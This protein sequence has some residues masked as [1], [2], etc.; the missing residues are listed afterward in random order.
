MT[1]PDVMRHQWNEDGE[2][3]LKCGAK[4]WMG[5]PCI[6]PYANPPQSYPGAG[7]FPWGYSVPEPQSQSD[8][9]EM[10]R[11]ATEFQADDSRPKTG[12]KNSY[13]QGWKAASARAEGEI[14]RLKAENIKYQDAFWAKDDAL[15]ES[16]KENEELKAAHN[17]SIEINSRMEE[18]LHNQIAGLKEMIEN[19]KTLLSRS[20]V[21]I[22]CRD[23]RTQSQHALMGSRKG[24]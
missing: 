13:I 22:L 24:N 5:G 6:Q 14:A 1:K 18:G 15:V 3:C 2:R 9:D 12:P 23:K 10:E 11:L 16:K 8:A 19:H 21:E 4:D 20:F 17:V 7:S